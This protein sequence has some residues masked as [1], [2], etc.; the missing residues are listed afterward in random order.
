[1]GYYDFVIF[2]GSLIFLENKENKG[3]NDFITTQSIYISNTYKHLD[4]Y[5]ETPQFHKTLHFLS[6]LTFSL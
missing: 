1:M 6:P 5:F 4:Y 3:M 2:I